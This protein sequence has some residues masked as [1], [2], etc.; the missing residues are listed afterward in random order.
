MNTATKFFLSAGICMFVLGAFPGCKPA[1][2]TSE[3]YPSRPL[4]LIVPWN[5]GGGTDL[6]S[7]TMAAVLQ[8]VLGQP[9]NVV[10]RTGGGGVVGHLALS[11]AKPDGY[12]LGA[13]TMEITMMHW[14][15]LT[16]LTYQDFT[17]LTL[18]MNNAA[19]ITVRKDAP[20]NTL[21]ELIADIR[22]YPG[23][24]RASGTAK[25]GIW[26]LARIGFLQAAGL[27]ESAL[28][29]VPTQGVSPALQELI[30]GGVDV[31]T[32]AVAEVE[33]MRKAG[34]VKVLAVMAPERLSN[35]PDIPTLKEQGVDWTLGGWISLGAP[36]GLPV[37]VVA[38]LDSAL[39]VA[40]QQP[41]YLEAMN[42]AGY[43]LQ[44]LS[45]AAFSEFIAEQDR[46]NGELIQSA[47]L[48]R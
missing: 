32:G 14:Q 6:S 38:K 27:P 29:W 20:W 23:K 47:G 42:K 30:A 48:A 33:G 46:I 8:D 39:T 41:A 16:D 7:R 11:R 10:N 24:F 19:S 43:N 28:P 17:P 21:E 31:V 26:D 15:G 9:V 1:G 34:E 18:I 45:A 44:P 40:A 3:N 25:G 13:I 36:A 4:T 22:T 5:P 2:N 12:T 35:F 37:E